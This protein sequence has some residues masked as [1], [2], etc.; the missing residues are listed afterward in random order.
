MTSRK[1]KTND[2]RAHNFID[3]FNALSLAAKERL[4]HLHAA[5]APDGAASSHHFPVPSAQWPPHPNNPAG[6]PPPPIL[7]SRDGTP[8]QTSLTMQHAIA[9]HSAPATPPR[10]PVHRPV[11]GPLHTP[12]GLY[13][14]APVPRPDSVPLP[15]PP[16]SRS[17]HP[18]TPQPPKLQAP[19]IHRRAQSEPLSPV[20]TDNAPAIGGTRQCGGVTAAGRQC[21]KQV[22]VS[23]AQ[24]LAG[25]D[26]FCNVHGKKMGDVSGFYDRKTGQTFVKF[27][28]ECT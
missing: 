1:D 7:Y 27:E 19:R 11:A 28:G 10:V 9:E 20:S 14:D 5:P 4:H 22:K 26:A 17:D 12:A 8:L 3:S 21:R 6:I 24:A 16:S 25:G 2:K 18:R 23:D 13:A 15:P